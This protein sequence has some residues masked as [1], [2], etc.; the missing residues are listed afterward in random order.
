MYLLRISL[1]DY[2]LY[3]W[4]IPLHLTQAVNKQKNQL[5]NIIPLH[6]MYIK[7]I[8]HDKYKK[9]PDKNIIIACKTKRSDNYRL[10]DWHIVKSS[11][12]SPWDN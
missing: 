3:R 11:Y 7:S 9:N 4:I 6:V 8:I 12:Q 5:V 10:D 2:T 1:N